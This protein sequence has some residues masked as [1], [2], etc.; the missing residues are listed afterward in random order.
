[1]GGWL[2]LLVADLLRARVAGMVGIAA[3]PD[4]TDWGHD[5]AARATLAAGEVVLEDNP[6]GPEPTP[7]YPAFWADGQASLRL[8][9]PIEFAGP[10]RLLHGQADPDVP[11]DIA[12]RLGVALRS[13]DVQTVLIKDGDHRLSRAGDIAL[14]LTTLAGLME[15]LPE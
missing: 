12:L 10:V 11:W 4:F 5:D 1:M 13:A 9:A 3:A 15:G 6:Y 2:M 14:L 8:T 7:T